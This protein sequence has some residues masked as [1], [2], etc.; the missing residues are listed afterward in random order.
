M[1]GLA[2]GPSQ[3]KPNMGFPSSF[4][5]V[6]FAEKNSHKPHAGTQREFWKTA[7]KLSVHEEAGGL[8]CLI[9]GLAQ[10]DGGRGRACTQHHSAFSPILGLLPF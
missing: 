8:H 10:E 7:E 5:Q 6:T 2:Q 1:D 3:Q 4:G 9:P